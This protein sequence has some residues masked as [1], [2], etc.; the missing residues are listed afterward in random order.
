M[1][2][3]RRT[4]ILL[5]VLGV[6]G[7]GG[8]VL[9]AAGYQ[10]DSPP[11][12]LLASA[13]P[14]VSPSAAAPSAPALSAS[15]APAPTTRPSSSSPAAAATVGPFVQTFAD[16]PGVRPQPALPSPT[17]TLPIRA[18]IDGCDRNYGSVSQC[19]PWI[20]PPGTTDKCAW[21]AAHGF[22]DLPIVGS[23]RQ[24]LDPDGNGTACD[25]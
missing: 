23:D 6:L 10:P 12:A 15:A 1:T 18:N 20:F 5:G 11:A 4:A 14:S 9:A 19:V 16:Q 2:W 25:D 8:W 7:L 17:A 3:L 21:L 13:S 22:K 24:H